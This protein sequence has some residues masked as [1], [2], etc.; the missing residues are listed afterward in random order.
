MKLLGVASE[1]EGSL[2]CHRPEVQLSQVNGQG[3]FGVGSAPGVEG[4][5]HHGSTI[6]AG[7]R[8]WLS[9]SLRRHQ[10]VRKTQWSRVHLTISQALLGYQKGGR[11]V[12]MK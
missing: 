5:L 6:G 3:S 9:D 8:D 4:I 12:T 10:L 11:Q 1:S 2:L 7:H